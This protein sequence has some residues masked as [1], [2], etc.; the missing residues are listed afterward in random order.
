MAPARILARGGRSLFRTRRR[1]FVHLLSLALLIAQLGMAAH[2]YSHLKA[3]SDG[4]PTQTQQICGQCLSFATRR[5]AGTWHCA[6]PSIRD[7]ARY[8]GC[9]SF[10]DAPPRRFARAH[11]LVSF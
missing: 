7:R 9:S 5:W 2:A 6:A 10:L 1:L 3:D 4:L 8:R 11:L